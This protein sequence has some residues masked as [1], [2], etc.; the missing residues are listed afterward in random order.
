MAGKRGLDRDL[1]SLGIAH[2]A[3]HDDVWVLSDDGPQ[4][5]GEGQ[6]DLRFDLHLV[7]PLNVV[8]N[9]ILDRDDHSLGLIQVSQ[10]RVKGGRFAAAGRSGH[11]QD[12]V[13]RGQDVAHGLFLRSA[14]S[15]RPEIQLH[16]VPE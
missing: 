1:R 10:R 6:P 8:L 9:R 5:I 12:A 16:V 2:F 3:D 7:D 15:E 13:R 11:Q 14:E 4:R